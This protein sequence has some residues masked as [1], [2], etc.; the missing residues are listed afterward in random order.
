M[1]SQIIDR[2][3][4]ERS[5]LLFYF[6]KVADDNSYHVVRLPFFE[7]IKISEKKK[8]RFKKYD[9][10][11]RS[12]N[13]Y[14]YLGADSRQFSLD[15]NLT[16]PHL[17]D[18]HPDA[19]KYTEYVDTSIGSS[20]NSKEQQRF[21]NPTVSVGTNSGMAYKLG[22]KYTRELAQTSA[23]EVF[24]LLKENNALQVE[25]A[26]YFNTRYSI[27]EA[28][29]FAN[30]YYMTAGKLGESIGNLIT[31]TLGI[32]SSFSFGDKGGNINVVGTALGNAISNA[33][34]TKLQQLQEVYDN[35]NKVRNKIIDLL[36][37]WV[38]IIRSSVCNNTKNPLYGPPIVRLR[39]GILYQ[40]VPCIVQ[41]YGFD[42]NEQAGYDL[43][44]LLPRQIR[45][46]LKLEELRTGDFTEFDPKSNDVIKRDNL[47]GWEAVIEGTSYSMDPG[48]GGM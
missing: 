7:N 29:T 15:F 22:T 41:D 12:S 9:L 47:T 39:H 32:D 16:L 48:S 42:F 23:K 33:G 38:N 36:V 3:L 10:V 44:T 13:L 14:S 6:P 4:P 31:K 18:L 43:D 34:K 5:M 2:A 28:A 45:V 26:L 20:N 25:N 37:Y 1:T 11:S 30:N 8:A 24:D 19:D 35:D 27:Q 46:S 17:L 21:F 40:D